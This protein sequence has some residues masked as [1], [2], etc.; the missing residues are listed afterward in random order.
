MAAAIVSATEYQR[1]NI[2]PTLERGYLDATSLAE[3]LVTRGIPFRTAHRIVG[4][5]V[6]RCERESKPA[7]AQLSIEDFAAAVNSAGAD[8]ALVG[9]D[10]YESLGARNVVGRYKSA[11]AA[12]G[13]PYVQRLAEWKARLKV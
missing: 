7:L 13:E 11:G 2:E 9:K 6:A 1:A 12:G 8:G 10:V 4:S 5:L 3:Y